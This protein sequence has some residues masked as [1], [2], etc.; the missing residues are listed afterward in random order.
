MCYNINM[1]KI[2]S[3]KIYEKPL[4]FIKNNYK[5][6]LV[7]L[8][9]FLLITVRLDYEIYMPGGLTN[10]D[11]RITVEGGNSTEGSFNLTY[12]KA[13]PGTIPIILLS[14]A[15][16]SW[17]LISIGD[18]RIDEE[19]KE[20]I[21][22]RGKIDL[23]SSENK[24]VK[25]A[26]DNAGVPYEIINRKVIVYHTLEGSITDLLV[27][28]II[29]SIDGKEINTFED[30]KSVIKENEV[31]STLSIN[32]IR[33]N[34]E[35]KVEATIIENDGEKVLGLYLVESFDIKSDVNVKFNY[36]GSES[37]SSGGLMSTLEIYNRLIKEDITKGLKIAGT[38]TINE[39]GTVGEIAGVKYKL[40][41]AVKNKADIFI[42][43]E[44]NYK[45]AKELKEKYN[46]KIKLIKAKTFEGVLEELNKL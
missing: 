19:S 20:D 12:V 27:G 8:F 2:L 34:K 5:F 9:L 33:E 22:K 45:E 41:G 1:K 28:D 43:P 37:G 25:V 17:D 35:K 14:Y 26:F 29:K 40:K 23:E 31:N 36:K 4:K 16:P 30:L 38:G 10:L 18:E 21:L 32:V 13:K 15:I 6:L 24:A 44:E 42:V 3:N 7:Y 39:D 46:Y 11:K